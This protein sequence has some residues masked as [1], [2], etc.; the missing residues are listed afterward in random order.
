MTV[1]RCKSKGSDEEVEREVV[2]RRRKV[3]VLHT[4]IIGEDF[5]VN[6]PEVLDKS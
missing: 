3:E 5:W 2:R 4:D 6:H 1:K